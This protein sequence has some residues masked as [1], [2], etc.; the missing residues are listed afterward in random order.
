[1]KQ[2]DNELSFSDLQPFLVRSSILFVSWL[3]RFRN[4]V[5]CLLGPFLGSWLTAPSFFPL[6]A[7]PRFAPEEL[8]CRFPAHALSPEDLQPFVSIGLTFHHPGR[9]KVTC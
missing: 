9:P 1:M 3:M 6:N 2:W 7:L 8:I 5:W 4:S